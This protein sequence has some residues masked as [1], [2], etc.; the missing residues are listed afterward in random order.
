MRTLL[1]LLLSLALLPAADWETLPGCKFIANEFNDGDSFHVA[2]GGR[3]FIF[4]LYFVD[5]PETDNS[6]PQ[7]VA[8]Q[9]AHFSASPERAIEIGRY[10]KAATA[11]MLSLPFTVITKFQ[12][13]R[14]R[15]N[16]PR[17]FAFVV[18]SAKTDL[19]EELVSSGLARAFGVAGAPPTETIADL[20]NRYD[21]LQTAAKRK[22]LGA[23]GTGPAIRRDEAVEKATQTRIQPGK[24]QSDRPES[25][26][27]DATTGEILAGIDPMSRIPVMPA[28]TIPKD[29]Y[30]ESPGWK[31]KSKAAEQSQAESNSEKVSLNTASRTEL[32]SLP[33]IG[34]ELAARIIDGRPFET[35]DD[36]KRI[37]GVGPKKF[38]DISP[39]VAP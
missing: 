29:D 24:S 36:L 17:H 37:K 23:W 35:V 39:L 32:E 6:F 31:P 7:R 11:Q 4:R 19:G 34:P 3:E 10:A 14:G 18:T 16:L 13:A 27:D 25:S 38:A 2:H 9:A 1:A 15:S 28:M 33:G 5:A 20:R 30:S 21:S 12:D 8:E 26:I 22:Q